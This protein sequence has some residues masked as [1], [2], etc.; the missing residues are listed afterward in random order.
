MTV[1]EA[2]WLMGNVGGVL[3]LPAYLLGRP[4]SSLFLIAV[5][6]MSCLAMGGQPR[7]R[8]ARPQASLDQPPQW[9]R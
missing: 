3:L 9:R 6:S 1:R 4:Y 8:S 2:L 7:G 5:V